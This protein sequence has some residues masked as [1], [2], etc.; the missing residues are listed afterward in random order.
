MET[1]YAD[2]HPPIPAGWRRDQ[3]HVLAATGPSRT[4]CIADGAEMAA[5]SHSPFTESMHRAAPPSTTLELTI[6]VSSRIVDRQQNLLHR[7]SLFQIEQVKPQTR[8][9]H[10][11]S[12]RLFTSA[13][14]YNGSNHCYRS[15][16]S[17]IAICGHGLWSA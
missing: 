13:I 10:K 1:G 5:S 11:T 17:N 16:C 15:R 14:I 8:D 12:V 2:I 4:V 9:I 3:S 7:R 6:Y